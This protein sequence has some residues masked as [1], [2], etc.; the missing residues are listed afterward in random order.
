MRV[1]F[2]FRVFIKISNHVISYITFWPWI[3]HAETHAIWFEQN[4]P[5]KFG[6]VVIFDWYRIPIL[7]TYA[8]AAVLSDIT[9]M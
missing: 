9:T 4:S 1:K 2:P 8:I 5:N 6:Q 3:C 7:F